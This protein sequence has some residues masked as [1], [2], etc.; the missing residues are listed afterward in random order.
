[1]ATRR[2]I[3]IITTSYPADEPGKEAAGGFVSD[4]ATALARLRPVHVVAPGRHDA[5]QLVSE[6]LTI[7]RYS[8]PDRALS[9]LRPGRPRDALDII[10]VLRAGQRAT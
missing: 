7:F 10:K 2:P 1:M 4:V 8:A 3:V 6:T 9:T 5:I